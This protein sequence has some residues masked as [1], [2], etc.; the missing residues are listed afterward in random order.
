MR[1]GGAWSLAFVNAHRHSLRHVAVALNFPTLLWFS[2]GSSRRIFGQKSKNLS[3]QSVLTSILS[4]VS[5]PLCVTKTRLLARKDLGH[6]NGKSVGIGD[7]TILREGSSFL[8][9]VDCDSCDI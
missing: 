5:T 2:E 4:L 9:L 8:C 1:D 7:L 6:F 3:H